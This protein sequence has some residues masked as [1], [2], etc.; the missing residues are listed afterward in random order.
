MLSIFNFQL[1][2]LCFYFLDYFFQLSNFFYS[3]YNFLLNP[4]ATLK[5]QR[6]T[7][8]ATRFV[9]TN[10]DINNLNQTDIIRLI[11]L[12]NPNLNAQGE[13]NIRIPK[14]QLRTTNYRRRSPSVELGHELSL[15][16]LQQCVLQQA[17][18]VQLLS[19]GPDNG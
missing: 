12:L 8:L 14:C 9:S 1:L 18:V 17:R 19:Q 16:L 10:S 11:F 2:F 4:I 13:P 3:C 6:T 7:F 5:S 15:V